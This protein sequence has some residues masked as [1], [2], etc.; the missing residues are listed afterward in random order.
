MLYCG[1][2][3]PPLAEVLSEPIVRLLM[4]RD[5]ER[6]EDL[7]ADLLAAQ[8]RISARESYLRRAAE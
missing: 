3:E 1:N 4:Q 5:G 8:I 7:L 2:R 6:L